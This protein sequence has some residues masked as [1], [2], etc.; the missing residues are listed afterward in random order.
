MKNLNP[1]LEFMVLPAY[2]DMSNGG[3]IAGAEIGAA[4]PFVLMYL[5][6]KLIKRPRMKLEYKNIINEMLPE[7]LN[8]ELKIVIKLY[9]TLLSKN[10]IHSRLKQKVQQV[11]TLAS[12]ALKSKDIEVKKEFLYNIVFKY[13]LVCRLSQEVLSKFDT[14]MSP[15]TVSLLTLASVC[16]GISV[17]SIAG[18]ELAR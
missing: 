18:A 4:S 3:G 13:G 12:N 17:G 16:L 8:E 7:E 9:S 2:L 10:K 1:L 15:N 5:Y 14:K 11:V 6:S